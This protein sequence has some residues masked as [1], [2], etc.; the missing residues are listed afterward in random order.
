MLDC[1]G[2]N[3][4][5]SISDKLKKDSGASF[6]NPSLYKSIIDSL[7]YVTLTMPDIAFLVNK[8]SQFLIVPIVLHWQACKRVLHYFQSTSLYG[9]RFFHFVSLILNAYFDAY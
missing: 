4:S 3:T 1:K 9:F 7:Q 6:E 5:M 8:L 2:Y